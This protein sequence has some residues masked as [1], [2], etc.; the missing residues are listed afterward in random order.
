MLCIWFINYNTISVSKCVCAVMS[1]LDDDVVC[2]CL[3][4]SMLFPRRMLVGLFLATTFCMTAAQ[5]HTCTPIDGSCSH[6]N[7]I[8]ATAL[9]PPSLDAG[10]RY[11]YGTDTVDCYQ[12]GAPLTS[13]CEGSIVD[14][15][16]CTVSSCKPDVYN[17]LECTYKYTCEVC[18]RVLGP[19]SIVCVSVLSLLG[20]S[21]LPPPLPHSQLL[22]RATAVPMTMSMGTRAVHTSRTRQSAL[23]SFLAISL[24]E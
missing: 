10:C 5:V 14:Q 24:T 20:L 22:S 16:F 13:T 2:V 21:C 1:P 17:P 3:C 7:L 8:N 19:G 11:C 23:G 12:D 9:V 4:L 18:Q 6:C 15:N